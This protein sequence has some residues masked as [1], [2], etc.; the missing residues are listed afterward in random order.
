MKKSEMRAWKVGESRVCV[1]FKGAGRGRTANVLR[2]EHD[3]FLASRK[4]SRRGYIMKDWRLANDLERQNFLGR[5]VPK[6]RPDKII[7]KDRN[8]T[9]FVTVDD[10]VSQMRDLGLRILDERKLIDAVVERGGGVVE[11]TGGSPA[12]WG[13]T[14]L[15]EETARKAALEINTPPPTARV[16]DLTITQ[17]EAALIAAKKSNGHARAAA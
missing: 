15:C 9:T 16:G 10:V 17:L 3:V 5:L 14:F 12:Q 7:I 13:L 6:A 11:L 4:P 2:K 8:G 1:C